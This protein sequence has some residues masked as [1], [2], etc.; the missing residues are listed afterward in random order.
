MA[1]H[2]L[3]C[4]GLCCRRICGNRA[5]AIGV[6]KGR[7]PMP[8]VVNKHFGIS[9]VV[10]V[11]LLLLLVSGMAGCGVSTG[12]NGGGVGTS[13]GTATPGTK[14]GA[15]GCATVAGGGIEVTAP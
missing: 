14:A 2:T 3:P 6:K 5:M 8:Y 9:P 11:L 15:N 13:T 4:V 7:C 10:A 12:A 1:L